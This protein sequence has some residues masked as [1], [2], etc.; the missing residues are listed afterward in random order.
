MAW[1]R[2]RTS[3]SAAPSPKKYR[4]ATSIPA[5]SSAVSM[6]DSSHFHARVA[7]SGSRKW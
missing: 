5:S 6:V 3:R 1:A 2:S 7:L 4:A